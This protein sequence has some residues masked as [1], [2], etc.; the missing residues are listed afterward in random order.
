M[1]KEEKAFVRKLAMTISDAPGYRDPEA[2]TE[3][4][5][6]VREHIAAELDG[7][8]KKIGELKAA[9]DEEGEE[10]LGDDLDRIDARME[11][12]NEALRGADY[13][14]SK[15]FGLAEVP[16]EGLGKVCAYDQALLEDLDLLVGDVMGM[17][18]EAIGTLTLR[19]VEGT[20]AAIELKIT[21]RKDVF[22][23]SLEG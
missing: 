9:A 2:R 4:D 14:D 22:D 1:T 18:Y 19:E 23:N 7:L 13:K 21:N 16:D 5:R 8:R 20:L 10:D 6:L 15:F 17:K 12:T 3:T 11:R